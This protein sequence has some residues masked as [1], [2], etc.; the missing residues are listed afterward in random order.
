M[1]GIFDADPRLDQD[2]NLPGQPVT[3]DLIAEYADAMTNPSSDVEL[4]RWM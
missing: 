4:A 2:R 3:S 1:G